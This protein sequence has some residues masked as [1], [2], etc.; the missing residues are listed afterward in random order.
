M[1]QKFFVIFIQNPNLRRHE[2]YQQWSSNDQKLLLF[3]SNMF[4]VSDVK[5]FITFFQIPSS[6][7]FCHLQCKTS[8]SLNYIW[9]SQRFYKSWNN[10]FHIRLTHFTSP[11]SAAS[12]GSHNSKAGWNKSVTNLI[13]TEADK[14]KWRKRK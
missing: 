2:L 14:Q 11:S 12:P 7:T 4:L 8:S 6:S 5:H 9:H 10:Q 1:Q 3:T 13:E